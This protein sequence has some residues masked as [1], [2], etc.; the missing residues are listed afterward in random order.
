MYA[1][2]HVVV[3][4]PRAR[5]RGH[6]H[7]GLHLCAVLAGGFVEKESSGWRDVGPGMVRVSGAARHDIDFSTAGAGCLVLQLDPDALPPLSAARF[8]APDPWLG[9]FVQRLVHAVKAS[10]GFDTDDFATELLAQVARRL[11]GR[12]GP[13]PPWLERVR[14]MASDDPE[15]SVAA[16]AA[17]AR[18]HRVHLAR[19]FREHCGT[20]VTGFLQRARVGRARRLLAS[21]GMSLAE[22]AATAGFAD[23]S[24]MTR[25]MRRA[26]GATPAAL[27]RRVLHRF[28]TD[29]SIPS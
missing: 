11:D 29:A 5:F 18:V 27:R 22:I 3:M 13:P 19:V 15:T 10:N 28:K 6:E 7:D 25:A 26:L 24:H 2:Q 23:Q 1:S 20:S 9:R 16:L 12:S 8:L 14:E 4:P 21:T 17:E